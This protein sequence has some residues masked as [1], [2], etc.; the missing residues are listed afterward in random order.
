MAKPTKRKR[1]K[2]EDAEGRIVASEVILRAT[3]INYALVAALDPSDPLW[4]RCWLELRC[5][6]IGMVAAIEKAG[7]PKG[8]P[9]SR[10]LASRRSAPPPT[11]RRLRRRAAL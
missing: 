4:R 2:S 6:A 7:P 8:H 9:P 1:S 10:A 5:A 11:V 3:A